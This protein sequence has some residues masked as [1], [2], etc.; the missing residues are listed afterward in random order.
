MSVCVC[1]CVSCLPLPPSPDEWE[2]MCIVAVNESVS[3]VFKDSD[4]TSLLTVIGMQPPS[5]TVR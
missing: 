2:E 4:F 1:V 5:D 3:N